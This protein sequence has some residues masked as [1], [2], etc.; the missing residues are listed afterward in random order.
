ASE[1]TVIAP[2]RIAERPVAKIALAAA[3]SVVTVAV[4]GWIGVQGG[5]AP[6]GPVAATSPITSAIQPVAAKAAVPSSAPAVNVQDYLAA[7]RQIPSPELYRPVV[8]RAPSG[9]R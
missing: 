2:R 7:H 8:N 1:P 6:S 9:A 4:V 5:P 3:A